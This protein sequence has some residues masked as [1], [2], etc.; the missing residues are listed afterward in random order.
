MEEVQEIA[1]VVGEA[2][3]PLDED[4]LDK[5]MAMLFEESLNPSALMNPIPEL[6]KIPTPEPT[7]QKDVVE[8]MTQWANMQHS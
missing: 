1:D 3:D 6:P 2:A 8:E 5:E 4:A 7:P